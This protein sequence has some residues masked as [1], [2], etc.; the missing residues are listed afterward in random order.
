MKLVQGLDD[1][2]RKGEHQGEV[3]KVLQA[4]KL[5]VQVRACEYGMLTYMTS[6]MGACYI[7]EVLYRTP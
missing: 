4:S 5:R 3:G 7:F 1:D 6:S 2:L